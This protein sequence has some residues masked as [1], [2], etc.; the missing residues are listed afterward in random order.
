MIKNKKLII[1]SLSALFLLLA[2]FLIF[3][4]SWSAN[5][6]E[7]LLP[8]TFI[9]NVDISSLTKDLV[10]DIL[11]NKENYIRE[12]G[13]EFTYGNETKVFPLNAASASPDIPESLLYADS[14]NFNMD[15][16]LN[17]I[18]SK[19]NRSFLKYLQTKFNKNYKNQLYLSFNYQ[20]DVVTNWLDKNFTNLNIKPENAYF[21][22]E[23]DKL[24][25]NKEKIGKE[26]DKEDLTQNINNKIKKL[27]NLEIL[28]KTKSK[29]PTITQNNLEFLR[30]EAENILKKGNFI[31]YYK[32]SVN[33]NEE[34]LEF[35]ITPK[36]LVTWITADD[37]NKQLS[38]N[39]D[40]EKIKE[41]LKEEVAQ[42]I[43]KEVVLPRFEIKDN[44]VSS[45]Q[46]GKDGREIDLEISANNILSGLSAN[47]WEA[48]IKTK[49]ISADDLSNE[50]HFKIK[51]IIGV[52]YSDFSGSPTN[53]RHNI[54]V[55]AEA[56]H[57]ILIKPGE[58]FSLVETLGEIDAESGYLPE[59]VIKGDKTIPE[60]GGGLCQ[61]ATT[62]F[63]S[64]LDSGLPITARR[65]HSY[66]VS[67]YEPAGT[68]AAVYDPWPDVRFLNDTNNY[69]LIQSRIEGNEIYFDFWGTED[70]RVATT[71]DPVIYNIVKPPPTKI[72]ETDEL[73][74][75]EKKCTE[76]AHNGADAYFDYIVTYPEG[77][78]TTPIQEVRFNSHYVPWQE[79]CLVGK[80]KEEVVDE[81]VETTENN[82]IIKDENSLENT[83]N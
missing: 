6:R 54:R 67:Y 16:N 33:Q 39:F 79:V 51:E 47:I 56:V 8:K 25:N 17:N 49:I 68:D 55:G 43:N 34:K 75:G 52:G 18:F 48:E 24:I 58:E 1:I 45:W 13:I 76:S 22:I 53:R 44:K 81:D 77:A 28:I 57:G 42:Q 50:N 63:R 3:Y 37:R 30:P 71:T 41:Y 23:E 4:L 73:E 74:P 15:E 59:L 29:Y 20:E 7:K 64:A 40:T 14:F 32:E 72:I 65:N 11:K 31:A 5:Y 38:L 19:K 62:L 21:S 36:K 35:T 80:E 66:R 83:E 9:G 82:G 26:L 2:I 69:I 46:V 12:S 70:G 78:T 61:I 60:Y 10:I 27:E